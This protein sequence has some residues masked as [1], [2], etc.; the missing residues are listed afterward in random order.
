MNW[1]IETA[2][3]A[4]LYC[5]DFC[6]NIANVLGISYYEAN[7]VMFCLIFPGATLGLFGLWVVQK[8]RYKRALKKYGH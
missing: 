6:I 3:N 7:Y 5:T 1:M 2:V 4:Y 8:M